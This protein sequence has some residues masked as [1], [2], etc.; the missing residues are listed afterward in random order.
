LN[1]LTPSRKILHRTT[2]RIKFHTAV[3]VNGKLTGGYE[4]LNKVWINKNIIKMKIVW[5]MSCASGCYR[6]KATVI[7]NNTRGRVNRGRC[8][9]RES[10]SIGGDMICG[11]CVKISVMLGGC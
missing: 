10:I 2:K 1:N 3:I 5:N 9:G 6:Y 4:V 8:S 11:A 7:D